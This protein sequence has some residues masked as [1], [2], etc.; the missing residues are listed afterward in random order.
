MKMSDVI[1]VLLKNESFGC[2]ESE[3]V[4]LVEAILNFCQSPKTIA[5]IAKIAKEADEYEKSPVH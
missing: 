4:D 2:K 5:Q 3:Y 1:M